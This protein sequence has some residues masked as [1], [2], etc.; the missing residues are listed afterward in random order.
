MPVAG[1]V[2]RLLS[3]V[4]NHH[5]AG[6]S[7]PAALVAEVEALKARNE[8]LQGLVRTGSPRHRQHKNKTF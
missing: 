1:S 2:A 6:P 5:R 3:Q 7:S 4:S 8:H